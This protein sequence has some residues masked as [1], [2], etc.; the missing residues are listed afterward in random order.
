[1]SSEWPI[2][3][4]VQ[5]TDDTDKFTVE[6]FTTARIAHEL[7]TYWRSR[8]WW[9]FIQRGQD[10]LKEYRDGLGTEDQS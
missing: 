1:M 2:V 8:G 3:V 7:I 10:L 4:Q 6:K 9:C 5:R